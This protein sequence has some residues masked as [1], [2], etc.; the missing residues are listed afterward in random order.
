MVKKTSL[1]L[2]GS[3]RG[4]RGKGKNIRKGKASAQN[5]NKSRGRKTRSVKPP[6]APWLKTMVLWVLWALPV[7]LILATIWIGTSAIRQITER[8][9]HVLAHLVKDP[10]LSPEETWLAYRHYF[11]RFQ[12]KHLSPT[13]LATLAYQLSSGRQ[14]T[15]VPWRIQFELTPWNMIHPLS[16]QFGIMQF[17]DEGFAQASQ[18]CIKNHQPVQRKRWYELGGCSLNAFKTRGSARHSIE[19]AAAHMQWY[20]NHKVLATNIPHSLND[21]QS[22][23]VIQ[24]LC[25]HDFADRFLANHW[26]LTGIHSCQNKV[27]AE[28]LDEFYAAQIRLQAWLQTSSSHPLSITPQI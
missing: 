28:F 25:G 5:K 16:Y 24:H 9:Y 27:M 21:L 17:S 22:L 7:P 1:S 18:F 3:A 13:F 11:L 10:P 12:T 26:Q 2:H 19:L 15:R 23:V 6:P 20:I 4:S 8:P 14:W